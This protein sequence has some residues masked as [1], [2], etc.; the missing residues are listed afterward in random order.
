MNFLDINTFIDKRNLYLII[1]TYDEGKTYLIRTPLGYFNNAPH[2][3]A[4][5]RPPLN[6]E[7]TGPILKIQAEFESPGKPVE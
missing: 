7:T 3:G 1:R 6:S 5:S 2:W 4:I